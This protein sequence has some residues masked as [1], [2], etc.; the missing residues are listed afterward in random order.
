MRDDPSVIALVRRVCDGDQEAWNEIVERY[1]P[2]VWGICARYQLS[3]S[4]CRYRAIRTEVALF[5][6]DA[7]H[8]RVCASQQPVAVL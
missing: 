4:Y 3:R 5:R 7:P 2:L 8:P 6:G 1:S